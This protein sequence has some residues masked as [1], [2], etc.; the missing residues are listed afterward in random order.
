MNQQEVSR[1]LNTPFEELVKLCQDPIFLAQYTSVVYNWGKRDG[2]QEVFLDY[3]RM[4]R[5]YTETSIK[6]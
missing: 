2:K 6:N 5:G 3:N 1:I 4:F